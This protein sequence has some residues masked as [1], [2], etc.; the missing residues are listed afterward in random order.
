MRFKFFMRF[1]ILFFSIVLLINPFKANSQSDSAKSKH[2]LL[3]PVITK[4][5]ETGWA[6]GTAAAFNFKFSKKDTISRTSNMQA[7]VLYSLHQQFLAALNGTTFFPKENYILSHQLSYSSFPDKFWGMGNNT[8]DSA[9]EN[10]SYHQFYIY[11]HAQRHLGHRL[12]IG[13]LYEFQKVMHVEFQK[14]GIFD[15]ENIAGREGYKVSGLGLSFTY[16]TRND[17]F[18]PSKGTFAQLYFNH[19]NPLFGSDYNYTNI[20]IDYRKYFTI[21]KKQVLALQAYSFNNVGSEV[22]LRSIATLGGS[23]SMRGY[24]DGRYRDKEQLVFQ[25]E[26]RVPI[27]KRFGAVGFF[28]CG[29]VSNTMFNYTFADLK[30]S[31]G[32]GLRFALNKSEKLNLRL[33]Y[34]FGQ[35]GNS[36]LYFQLG[37]AF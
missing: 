19:F 32:G 22:P 25:A 4:S 26:Y 10:Y 18:A 33:D 14:G 6:F 2:L 24:Y 20:V 27:F 30:Y 34:G 31:G 23:G 35:K 7:L 28:S 13:G 8:P 12:F 5:I 16:D 37:E 17:A 3:F 1:A 15:K 11:L 29:D 9:E 36:G 21:Y